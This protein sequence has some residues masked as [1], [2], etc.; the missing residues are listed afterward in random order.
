M[1]AGDPITL[2]V[3][4]SGSGSL[5]QALPPSLRESEDFRVYKSRLVNEDFQRDGLTGRKIIEQVVIPTHSGVDE[6]PALEFSFYDTASRQY[7]TI[8]TNPI[9]LKVLEGAP[10]QDRASAISS[11]PGHSLELAPSLLGEDL[12]YLKLRPGNLR[13]L[14]ALEPGWVF[15][16]FSTLPF[17]LWGLFSLALNRKEQRRIDVA[18]TRRQQAP[19]RLRK[20]LSQLDQSSEELYATI[21]SILSDYL[22]ARLN[23]PAGELNPQ[24]VM[25]V[26]PASVAGEC[27]EHLSEWMRRC[28][29][30]RF[31]GRQTEGS[32]DDLRRD[33]RDFI[34]N[35]DRE[36]SA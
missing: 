30:A 5:R 14:R 13:D 12:I 1:T 33:F 28:E 26:L 6:I 17:A 22:G 29:R 35:L 4:L 34:L 21:W 32:D 15:T 11:L 19:R 2:R 24:E 10:G 25:Q 3:E 16:G 7:Q 23:L 9:P 27:R 20:H 31:A 8:Q 36:L 18:G